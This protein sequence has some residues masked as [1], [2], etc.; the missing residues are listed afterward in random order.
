MHLGPFSYLSTGLVL[1]VSIWYYDY[2]R[3]RAVEEV[4]Y[5]DERRR[6]HC[7]THYFMFTFEC[8]YRAIES[9]KQ[10]ESW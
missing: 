8:I 1:G 4:L 5:A 3:R 7:T 9:Y 6:Y 10:N 2:W